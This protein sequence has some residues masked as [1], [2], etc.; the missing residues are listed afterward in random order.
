MICLFV[1]CFMRIYR[2]IFCL[3]V[4]CFTC[5]VCYATF[6]NFSVIIRHF[7]GHF[8]FVCLLLVSCFANFNTCLF[9]SRQF[10]GKLPVLP[11]HLSQYHRGSRN[12]NFTF[13]SGGKVIS[14]IML[15]K[16]PDWGSNPRPTA[17]EAEALP[18]TP[19][20]ALRMQLQILTVSLVQTTSGES[21]SRSLFLYY[22]CYEHRNQIKYY[23]VLHRRIKN[24]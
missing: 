1:S 18:L 6:N 23:I 13:L 22:L 24:N 3:F 11:V 10:H 5:I 16:T 21:C 7:Q 17:P 4:C 15:V 14:T 20:E 8:L 9:I 2:V 12:D 19:P